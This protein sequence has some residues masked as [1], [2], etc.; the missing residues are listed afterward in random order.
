M[1]K[2]RKKNRKRPKWEREIKAKGLSKCLYFNLDD[3]VVNESA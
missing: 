2:F 3:Y 1:L